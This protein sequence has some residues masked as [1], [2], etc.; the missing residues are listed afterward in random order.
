MLPLD[1]MFNKTETN[2]PFS[3]KAFDSA[4]NPHNQFA[5]SLG[6]EI[7]ILVSVLVLSLKLVSVLTLRLVFCQ[8][9]SRK[10]NTGL[11]YLCTH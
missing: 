1:Q 4:I 7:N 10:L 9:Q 11:A 8:P 2:E 6:L 5:F 3:S